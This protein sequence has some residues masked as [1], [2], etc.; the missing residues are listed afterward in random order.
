[1]FIKGVVLSRSMGNED[2]ASQT[3]GTGTEPKLLY[4]SFILFLQIQTFVLSLLTV[5]SSVSLKTQDDGHLSRKT[6]NVISFPCKPLQ[7]LWR[8]PHVPSFLRADGQ[9]SQVK[10]QNTNLE[11]IRARSSRI[12]WI[13]TV[14]V[15]LTD[16]GHQLSLWKAGS[17]RG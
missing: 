15:Q 6:S 13:F 2:R 9:R 5:W 3:E 14:A 10:D 4:P 1:M 8:L 7:V 16:A 11:A 12:P 17:P